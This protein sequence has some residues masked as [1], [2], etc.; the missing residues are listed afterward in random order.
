MLKRNVIKISKNE[1]KTKVGG[2]EEGKGGGVGDRKKK[3]E[4][5]R[6]KG[7]GGEGHYHKYQEVLFHNTSLYTGYSSPQFPKQK[8]TIG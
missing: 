4:R 8:K 7:G 2:G 5:S 3:K 6:L 1:I